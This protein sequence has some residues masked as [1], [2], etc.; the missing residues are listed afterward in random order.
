M[1]AASSTFLGWLAEPGSP[2]REPVL[3]PYLDRAIVLV[4]PNGCGKTRLLRALVDRHTPRLFATLPRRLT[5][6]LTMH[7]RHLEEHHGTAEAGDRELFERAEATRA[8]DD[9]EA[10]WC[11]HL[12]QPR[13][14]W[15]VRLA[16]DTAVVTAVAP[17]D[18]FTDLARLPV[19]SRHAATVVEP[20]VTPDAVE[21]AALD[22]AAA[23]GFRE[24]AAIVLRDATLYTNPLVATR[25]DGEAMSLLVLATTYCDLLAQRAS[26]RLRSLA[27]FP[28]EL[29]CRPAEDFAWRVRVDDEWIPLVHTSRAMSRWC[30]LAA[31]ET[32]RELHECA[33]AVASDVIRTTDAQTLAG[34][35]DPVFLPPGPPGPFATRSTWVAMDEPEVHLF[36]SEARVLG[37]ALADR[38]GVGR[39]LVATHSLELAARFAGTADFLVFD[40]PGHFTVHRPERGV[41]TLLSRLVAHGPVILAGTRVLYV[42][43][44]WDVELV[45]RL[46]GPALS[47]A[48][49]LLGRMHG[50]KGAGVA[51]S[52]VWQRM[53]A[54]PFGMMFD[55]V[56][57]DEAERRWTALR[58]VLATQGRQ[59]ATHQSRTAIRRAARGRHEDV[60]LI[61]LF[62]SVVEGGL[63]ERLR[64][65]MHGLSDIFQVVHPSVFGLAAASWSEAGYDGRVTF[66]DFCRRVASVDLG[67]GTQCRRILD[68]FDQAGRPVDAAA[69]AALAGAVESFLKD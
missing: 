51:A 30:T 10:W 46:H 7:R 9:A 39:T 52:S 37:D 38:G 56:R 69:A 14:W 47:A 44:D 68:A 42:E 27:G 63:E 5:P 60:E 48:N 58:T 15:T 17:E 1:T 24:W 12:N 53:M 20:W 3:V 18:P 62:H 11:A 29:R 8:Q 45:D 33:T 55:G 54:T 23:R 16:A 4:G 40:S 64:L 50:V 41:A 66:K 43:G 35:I 21:P 22:A 61:R 49:V 57:A 25:R 36:A 59:A 6:Y 28:L 26:A 31:T 2:F 32:L 13:L 65:V 19:A 67:D 34:T